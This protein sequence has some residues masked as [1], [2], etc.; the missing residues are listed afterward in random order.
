MLLI[1]WRT[2]K[3]VKLF[4]KMLLAKVESLLCQP[5]WSGNYNAGRSFLG[6]PWQQAGEWWCRPQNVKFNPRKESRHYVTQIK[7]VF[8][9]LLCNIFLSFGSFCPF[10][11]M[12]CSQISV[13][14]SDK[15]HSGF[16]QYSLLSAPPYTLGAAFT[17]LG[18][19]LTLKSSTFT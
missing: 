15:E 1:I 7:S 12:F 6:G 14:T 8:A 4:A 19:T 5:N 13:L 9:L 10:F 3:I 18:T 11:I 16:N 2:R 17:L